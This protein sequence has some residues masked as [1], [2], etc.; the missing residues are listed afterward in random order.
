[1]NRLWMLCVVLLAFPLTALAAKKDAETS[2]I[3]DWALGVD[4]EGRVVSLVPRGRANEAFREPLEAIV[5]GWEFEPGRVDGRPV[6]SE[7]SLRVIA[8]RAP[9][10][11]GGGIEVHAVRVGGVMLSESFNQKRWVWILNSV[12]HELANKPPHV[13][14]L[15]VSIEYDA[16]GKPVQVDLPSA[17]P[18][19]SDIMEREV[20]GLFKR[21]RY[22]PE[23][24]AGQAMPG[25]ILIPLCLAGMKRKTVEAERER[26]TMFCES[27]P[28]NVPGTAQGLRGNT[29]MPLDPQVHLK[30]R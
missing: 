11:E 23:K 15:V 6:A 16:K 25:R 21:A 12:A 29:Y 26:R 1:M 22:A 10:G 13:A 2:A 7:T 9:S 17:Y 5:R 8:T 27:Q 3:V 18:K 20:L 19:V 30:S 4:A 24:L 14:L 28:W